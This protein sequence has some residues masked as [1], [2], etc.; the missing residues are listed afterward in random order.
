MTQDSGL[1]LSVQRS[2]QQGAGWRFNTRPVALVQRPAIRSFTRETFSR[3]GP[4]PATSVRPTWTRSGFL[5]RIA[6]S[7]LVL[8]G[9]PFRVPVGGTMQRR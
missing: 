1:L 2:F 3:L 4:P 6:T 7:T 9:M 8:A 5:C